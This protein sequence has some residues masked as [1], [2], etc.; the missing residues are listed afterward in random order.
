[1]TPL[2]AAAIGWLVVGIPTRGSFTR[3]TDAVAL[4]ITV[5]RF[6]G[7][8]SWVHVAVAEGRR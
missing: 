5:L 6:D 4:G 7:R 1:M 2:A 8:R 3:S